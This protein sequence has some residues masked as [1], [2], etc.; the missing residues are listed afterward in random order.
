[1]PT[2]LPLRK[3]VAT[4]SGSD[5]SDLMVF[6]GNVAVLVVLFAG[7]IGL[8]RADPSLLSTQYPLM[9]VAP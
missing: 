2:T 7:M 4:Q 9:S 3:S 5:S 8:V 1:M 6:F